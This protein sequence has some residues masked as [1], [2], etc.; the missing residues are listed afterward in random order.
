L[1]LAYCAFCRAYWDLITWEKRRQAV[2]VVEKVVDEKPIFEFSAEAQWTVDTAYTAVLGVLSESAHKRTL[3]W[4]KESGAA[5]MAALQEGEK[6][7]CNLLRDI[8]GNPHRPVTADPAWLTPNVVSLAQTLYDDRAFN[9]LPELAD[10]LEEAG[11][12]NTDVLA[13]CR[14]PGPHVRGCWVVDLVLGKE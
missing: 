14:A 9:R 4:D 7:F 2:E 8:F 1:L 13:H 10:A 12:T 11:C 5:A 3:Y 6:C